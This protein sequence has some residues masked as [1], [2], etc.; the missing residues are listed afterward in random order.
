MML[1]AMEWRWLA[2]QPPDLARSRNAGN[3][4]FARLLA[5]DMIGVA[6]YPIPFIRDAATGARKY[7]KNTCGSAPAHRQV[8][9][10]GFWEGE[11]TIRA[12]SPLQKVYPTPP[13][14]H[15]FHGM[16]FR[17]S[18]EKKLALTPLANPDR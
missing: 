12:L 17:P 6:Q 11:P 14:S 5:R 4:C 7:L 3:R 2:L 10:V 16:R 18:D 15:S 8:K 9:R 13:P 1:D